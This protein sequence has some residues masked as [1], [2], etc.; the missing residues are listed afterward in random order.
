MSHHF[1]YISIHLQLSEGREAARRTW[2][3]RTMK[4]RAGVF[5]ELMMNT[6]ATLTS[7]PRDR[8]FGL[9]GMIDSPGQMPSLLRSD[10]A[11]SVGEVIRDGVRYCIEVEQ[12]PFIWKEISHRSEDEVEDP[13]WPSWVPRMNRTWSSTEDPGE[14]P[15]NQDEI[16]RHNLPHANRKASSSTEPN[17]LQLEGIVLDTISRITETLLTP[18]PHTTSILQ[19]SLQ[20]ILDITDSSPECDPALHRTLTADLDYGRLRNTST[21]S[22][23]CADFLAYMNLILGLHD[24]N[25]AYGRLHSTSHD[26]EMRASRYYA[27]TDLACPNRKFCVTEKGSYGLVPKVCKEGDVVVMMTMLRKPIVLRRRELGGWLLLGECYLD[28]CMWME[29]RKNLDGEVV[30]FEVW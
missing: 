2:D 13:L 23:T 27:A 8:V 16:E 12:Y 17:V 15:H 4:S 11:K 9:L 20:N 29:E 10:Y 18:L 19:T 1:P 6:R 25:I 22:E 26:D 7:D 14:L 21:P 24:A 30:G 28:G 5:A 3:L